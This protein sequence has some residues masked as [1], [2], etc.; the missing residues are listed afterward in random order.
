MNN[1]QAKTRIIHSV[2]SMYYKC[3]ACLLEMEKPYED[4]LICGILAD[5]LAH[6]LQ[7]QNELIPF[8]FMNAKS[9]G[10]P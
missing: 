1:L 4:L 10:V 9:H 8:F 7:L 6:V 2:F 5:L 3:N